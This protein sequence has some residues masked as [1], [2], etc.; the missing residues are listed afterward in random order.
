MAKLT[1]KKYYIIMKQNNAYDTWEIVPNHLIQMCP[2]EDTT[3]AKNTIYVSQKPSVE[4]NEMPKRY[5][6]LLKEVSGFKNMDMHLA[7]VKEIFKDAN[8]KWVSCKENDNRTRF[9]LTK[10]DCNFLEI[11]YEDGIEAIP[12][13]LFNTFKRYKE[14]TPTINPNDLST[15][16]KTDE[17]GLVK[18]LSFLI[19]GFHVVNSKIINDELGIDIN[20]GCNISLL[21]RHFQIF[22]IKE[23]T[24]IIY[25][26]ELFF[27]KMCNGTLGFTINFRRPIHI[28]EL[29]NK[30]INDFFLIL[31][32]KRNENKVCEDLLQSYMKYNLKMADN[33]T[34]YANNGLFSHTNYLIRYYGRF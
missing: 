14:E 9:S 11:D 26:F 8:G 5:Y 33:F 10:S 19:K 24:E 15:C 22:R 23:N 31:Y 28:E 13:E 6:K 12:I 2:I 4:D 20:E 18:Q 25:R 34:D 21:K 29:K 17:N 3:D 1:Q 7:F 32:Q 30:N 16:V 27:H